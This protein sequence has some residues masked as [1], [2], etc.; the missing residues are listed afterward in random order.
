MGVNIKTVSRL[1][2]GSLV[3][4]KLFMWYCTTGGDSC[5]L[6]SEPF[7]AFLK[8]RE[9]GDNALAACL[10][11]WTAELEVEESLG[12]EK[13]KTRKPTVRIATKTRVIGF[14]RRRVRGA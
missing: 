9:G 11:P 14:V 7:L 6:A 2:M 10:M 3:V 1:P 5:T 12:S 13:K 4:V 8:G